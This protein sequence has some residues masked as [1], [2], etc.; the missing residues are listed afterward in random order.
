VHQNSSRLPN[1]TEH[2]QILCFQ[3]NWD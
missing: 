1:S 2:V 3:Y